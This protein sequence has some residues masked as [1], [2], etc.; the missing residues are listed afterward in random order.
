[1][2][3]STHF[4]TENSRFSNLS[5]CLPTTGPFVPYSGE[6]VEVPSYVIPTDL[7][8]PLPQMLVSAYNKNP[9][10][11]LT[12]FLE[13]NPSYNHPREIGRILFNTPDVSPYANAVILFNSTFSSRA[14]IFS[15][16]TAIDLDCLSLTDAMRFVLARVAIPTHTQPL[17]HFASAFAHAYHLRNQLEWPSEVEVEYLMCTVVLQALTGEP[18]R[19]VKEGFASLANASKVLIEQI[20]A[21]LNEHPIPVYFSSLPVH[22]TPGDSIQVE[23]EQEGR[24]RSSWNT[25]S[26]EIKDQ[27]IYCSHSKTK[28]A[29]SKIPL[30]QVT[31][32]YRPGVP[33]KPWVIY[34]QRLDNME[35]GEK[36][37]DGAYKKSP[38][39]SYTI[40]FG[41][42][43]DMHKFL[44]AINQGQA[45]EN[46]K[47][48]N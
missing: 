5:Y 43:G 28:K 14:L 3:G 26:F 12:N 4:R 10:E 30:D 7:P 39:T 17:I 31:A 45:T 35:F 37:K 48:L 1:M 40:A 32:Y 22:N 23:A 44:S 18:F 21:S 42:E 19:Q 27:T 29:I 15:F 38:R 16:V 33:K 34:F 6:L 25:H 41:S 46:L 24:Y 13:S 11:V 2:Q 9:E 36:M 20:E 47:M 8:P